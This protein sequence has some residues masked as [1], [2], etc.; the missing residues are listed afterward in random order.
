[1]HIFNLAERLVKGQFHNIFYQTNL[2]FHMWIEHLGISLLTSLNH[3]LSKNIA[4]VGSFWYLITSC[5]C[6][7]ICICIPVFV[8]IWEYNFWHLWTTSYSKKY[9]GPFCLLITL[10]KC[11]KG[12]KSRGLLFAVVSGTSKWKSDSVTDARTNQRTN[13][14]TEQLTNRPTNPLPRVGSRL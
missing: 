7:C 9:A 4:S 3:Q 1:M 8:N 6:I 13:D 10:I 12:H 14:P 11:F 5:I 2:I